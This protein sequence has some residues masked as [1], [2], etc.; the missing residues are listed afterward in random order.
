VGTGATPRNQE[1]DYCLKA[2]WKELVGPAERDRI[3]D[4]KSEVNR[5][6]GASHSQFLFAINAK[7]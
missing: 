5:G 4:N 1:I 3:V 2:D 7:P 6:A